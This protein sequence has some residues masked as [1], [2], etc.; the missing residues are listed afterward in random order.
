LDERTLLTWLET[1]L[2]VFQ[3]AAS[4]RDFPEHAAMA[5]VKI[6]GLDA[7]AMLHCSEDGRWRTEAVCSDLKDDRQAA[8]APSQT[9]L[10]RVRRE[11]RTF[12]HVPTAGADT[13][14]SLQDVSALV[15]AP[16]LDGNGE[17][18]GALYGDRR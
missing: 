7:A 4:T 15:A 6:V 13:P 14:R 11:R 2:A 9:L 16:I 3:S 17:V 10:A 8:W 1:V 18:I 12:R 5:V